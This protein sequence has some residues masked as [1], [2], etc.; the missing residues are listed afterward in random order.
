MGLQFWINI[1]L[2]WGLMTCYRRAQMNAIAETPARWPRLRKVMNPMPLVSTVGGLFAKL[3]SA[4][5]PTL[6]NYQPLKVPARDLMRKIIWLSLIV[7]VGMIYGFLVS[8]F[9]VSFYQYLA[10]PI[11]II[12]LIVI[13]CLPETD[14][15]PLR[16]MIWLFWASFAALFLWPNY[17]AIALPG[18]PWITMVRL[19]NGPMMLLMLIA[20]SIGPTF[21]GRL[22][23]ILGDSPIIS[24]LMLAFFV[25]Q[26]VTIAWSGHLSDTF[27]RFVAHVLAWGLV[28]VVASYAFVKPGRAQ[29]WVHMLC[30]MAVFL[31]LLSAW[32]WHEARVLWADSIPSFLVVQDEAVQRM[33]AGSSRAAT[34][35]YRL[36]SIFSTSLNFAEFL[37]LSTVFFVHQFVESKGLF[38]RAAIAIYIPWHFWT[39]WCTDSRLGMIAFYG[40][41][42]LYPLFWGIRRWRA[43]SQDIFAPALVLAYP[44]IISI[45]MVASIYWQRLE[46][47]VWGGGEQQASND[48]RKEQ[49]AAM[50]PK[51]Y[52]WPIGHGPGQSGEAL[53][54]AN[55]DGIITVDSYYITVLM[56]YGV[57]GFFV[58]YGFLVA[59]MYQGYKYASVSRDKDYR[60]LMPASIMIGMF[61]VVKGVLSQEDSHAMIFMV[62]GMV[63]A[64]V[65]RMKQEER[66]SVSR[67]PKR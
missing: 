18:L 55:S 46:R 39:I 44:A 19:W 2:S 62:L 29:I 22:A 36:Q 5:P 7:F 67:R 47:M 12:A 31:S 57:I 10:I 58:F 40:S 45:F 1:R 9:P 48:S 42:L 27:N 53:G 60:L 4:A 15:P 30:L 24:W 11:L 51:L 65:H 59:G 17:I 63:T 21:R 8:I 34:G 26:F 37:G 33:L 56:E 38:R 23:A 13:W 66:D 32:E 50:W 14:N 54:Y 3:V 20:L 43:R 35:I 52:A 28:F 6:P 41:I 25:I 64:L 49:W 16:S 61:V